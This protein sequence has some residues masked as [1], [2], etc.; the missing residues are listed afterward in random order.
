MRY[1]DWVKTQSWVCKKTVKTIQITTTTI[2]IQQ[3]TSLSQEVTRHSIHLLLEIILTGFPVSGVPHPSSRFPVYDVFVLYHDVQL[4]MCFCFV[5]VSFVIRLLCLYVPV[6]CEA[7]SSSFKCRKV[8]GLD[9]I[10]NFPLTVRMRS[11]GLRDTSSN[12]YK[13]TNTYI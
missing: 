9:I 6:A 13:V 8:K 11:L 12:I 7:V 4:L 3:Q 2:Q 1:T 5:V 10:C